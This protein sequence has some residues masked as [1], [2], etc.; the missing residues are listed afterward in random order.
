MKPIRMVAR[1]DSP[2]RGSGV[3]E[4]ER[5]PR[6]YMED[7]SVLGLVVDRIEASRRIL[8]ARNFP[9]ETDRCGVRLPVGDASDIAAIVRIL[10]DNGISCDIG[11]LAD[12]IYQG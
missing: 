3:V 5:M 8:A 12:T 9:S 10:R 11:D 6:A 1:G 2:D 4:S 7:Y